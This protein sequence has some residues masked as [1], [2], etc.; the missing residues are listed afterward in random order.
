MSESPTKVNK[1]VMQTNTKRIQ[2]KY[3]NNMKKNDAITNFNSKRI[4]KGKR[5]SICMYSLSDRFPLPVFMMGFRDSLEG[6]TNSST[7]IVQTKH[8]QKTARGRL[9][10]K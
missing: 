3:S 7:A 6:T 5:K 1:V 2:K 4:R 8:K 10:S 9:K